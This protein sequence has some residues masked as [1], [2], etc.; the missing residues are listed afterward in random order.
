MN[1]KYAKHTSRLHWF[2]FIIFFL[3]A[4]TLQ[5]SLWQRQCWPY[6]LSKKWEKNS[7]AKEYFPK[8]ILDVDPFLFPKS[9]DA[10]GEFSDA[11]DWKDWEERIRRKEEP[12]TVEWLKMWGRVDLEDFP[13]MPFVFAAGTAESWWRRNIRK[14]S[15][16]SCEKLIRFVTSCSW[17]TI[18]E[19]FKTMSWLNTTN[20][21]TF[22]QENMRGNGVCFF[23]VF[24]D[25]QKVSRNPNSKYNGVL[26]AGSRE[27]R[28][29][30]KWQQHTLSH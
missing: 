15:M 6:L 27:S 26:S 14:I 23:S 9:L 4:S 16:L 19:C 25:Q 8:G 13:A 2:V 29:I 18:L 22:Y 28:Q 7:H 1:S 21:L 3:F 17:R 5:G 10:V 11:W 24:P 12:L 20:I 30:R